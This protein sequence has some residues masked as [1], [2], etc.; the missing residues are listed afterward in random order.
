MPHSLIPEPATGRLSCDAGSDAHVSLYPLTGIDTLAPVFQPIVDLRDGAIFGHEALIRGAHHMPAELLQHAARA[1]ML[2]EFEMHCVELALRR[3][4]EMDA[5]GRVFLN[6]SP[7]VLMHAM[8][9]TSVFSLSGKLTRLGVPAQRVVVELTE[10]EMPGDP[11]A[12][13]RTVKLLQSMGVQLALDDFGDAHSNLRRWSEL[14]PDFIKIDKFFT[15]EIAVR[16][17][18]I[19]VVRAICSMSE[20]F[21]TQVIA[22]GIANADD[23]RVLRDLDIAFGQGFMLGSPAK[24]P[25]AEIPAAAAAVLSASRIAVMPNSGPAN[26]A[27]LRGL[28]FRNAETIDART[29]NARVSEMFHERPDLHAL[30]VVEDGRAVALVNRQQF[31]NRYAQLYFREIHGRKPA[32]GYANRTPRIVELDDDVHKLVGILTSDDQSYLSEGFI[33]TQD[34]K[35]LGIGT[36]EQLVRAVTEMRIEAAQH[37]NPLTL[38]PGNI[39]V[40]VDIERLLVSGAEFVAC[41]ADLN[42]FKAFNDHYG[43]WRGDRLIRLGADLLS[44]NADGSRDFV[45]HIGGD[46]FIVLFQSEDW[47]RRCRHIIDEFSRQAAAMYDEADRLCGGIEADDR[48]GVNRFFPLCS[49][50]I[51]AVCI[52]AGEVGCAEDVANEAALAKHGAKIAASGLEI[53]DVGRAG[54]R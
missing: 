28:V 35:Y 39:P 15:H 13:R 2:I 25:V 44:R 11:H 1:S 17:E 54:H 24:A 29:T 7:G 9:D 48:H 53:R 23:L 12:L 14:K 19:Q 32:A 5:P 26:T 47:E 4:K 8:D 16:A 18:H 6:M 43:Y 33:V 46:D 30:A 31:M 21:G 10:Q 50:A 40:S 49:I 41:Y 3:W 37:A 27:V 52:K 22:E 42:N 34:G 45:G 20:A 36:G 51:G 38:L